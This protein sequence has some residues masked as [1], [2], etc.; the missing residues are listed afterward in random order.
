MSNKNTKGA[1]PE[2]EIQLDKKRKLIFDFNAICKLEEVTGKNAL[3]GETWSSLSATDVRALLWGALL[4]DDPSLELS[5]VGQLITFQNLPVI[6]EA[7][8][9]AF[10]ASAVPEGEDSPGKK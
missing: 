3:S 7:I 5:D 4:R 1:M 9:K 8:E 10:Q 6:T 2:I